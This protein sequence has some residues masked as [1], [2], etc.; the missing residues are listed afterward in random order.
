MTKRNKQNLSLQTGRIC[1]LSFGFLNFEFVSSFVLRIS[2][3]VNLINLI[4]SGP[5]SFALF[6]GQITNE[7]HA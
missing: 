5:N 7:K 3:L 6:V 2:K 1:F 4:S